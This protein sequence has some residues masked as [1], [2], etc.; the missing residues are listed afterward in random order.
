MQ[1]KKTVEDLD[2]RGKRVLVR[3]DFNV[4]MDENR[5]ITDD[6]RIKSALPTIK[7]ILENDGKVVLMSHLGRPKGEAK[8]EFSLEPV[9]KRLADLL[10][11]EV[12]F[13]EDDEVVG[14]SAKK[15]VSEM[16][17]G[18]VVLLQNTR[19]RKE[20]KKNEEEFA[21][22]LASLGDI[23]VNDAFGTA[24]R[25]HAS[26]VGVSNHLPSAIGYLVKRELDIMA[27]AISN[28]ERP[29]LAILGGAKVTDKIGVI[30]NLLDKVDSLIIGGGMSYTFLNAKGHEVG[31]SL[32]EKDKVNLAKE[33]MEKAEQK[34]VKLLLPVDIVITKEFK[35]DSEYKTVNIDSIPKDMM[36]LDIGEKTRDLFSEEIK[37]SKT[38][39]WNGPMGVF[40]MEN[41]AKGTN[42]IAE[43]MAESDATTIIGGGDSA[44]AVEKTGLNDKMTHISTGGG[45][46]LEL[47]EGKKLP[48]IEALED[49]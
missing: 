41:F 5:N 16:E 23:F 49:K 19:F 11:R 35:N 44:A 30:E 7:Y 37:N 17:I 34:N 31:T 47:F 45:A 46:S 4:P 40:E 28:P 25:A 43:A 9:A 36:G 1:N 27:G 33:L 2:I 8:K 18:D 20:E 6:R 12:I 32:L 24:H 29:F 38:V 42:R 3:C 48:G 13:A 14:E 26:N 39:I 15:A 10:G 21:K 22:S